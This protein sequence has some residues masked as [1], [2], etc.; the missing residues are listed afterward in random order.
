MSTT[1][2]PLSIV[3]IRTCFARSH[4][5]IF[6]KLLN[7]SQKKKPHKN[8]GNNIE[9]VGGKKCVWWWIYCM[10]GLHAAVGHVPMLHFFVSALSFI[11]FIWRENGKRAVTEIIHSFLKHRTPH[12]NFFH[13]LDCVCGHLL[14]ELI[15]VYK[16]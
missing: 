12:Y 1:W 5:F 10:F 15:N 11:S 9:I 14:G 16:G 2:N 13:Q 3:A 6:V 4:T 8:M 7:I